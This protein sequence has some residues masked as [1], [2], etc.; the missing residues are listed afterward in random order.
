MKIILILNYICICI[1]K[2]KTLRNKQHF[3]GDFNSK[4]LKLESFYM[5]FPVLSLL[6]TIIRVIALII[7][8]KR[9]KYH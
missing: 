9:S 3:R 8:I 1:F 7:L 5:I 2:L 6:S 4:V